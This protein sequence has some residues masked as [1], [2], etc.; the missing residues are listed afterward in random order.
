[1]LLK[2]PK[3]EMRQGILG[4]LVDIGAELA[5]M[6]LVVS[7]HQRERNAGDLK[8]KEVV[9]FFLV[10]RKIIVDGLFDAITN[11]AD[12]EAVA[13]ANALMFGAEELPKITQDPLPAKEREF[14]SDYSSGR[15]LNRK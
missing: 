1:M 14:C 10:Q 6:A 11:N 15:I 9:E 12:K 7:R 3:L 5:V 2:G 8:N 4:R 13:A